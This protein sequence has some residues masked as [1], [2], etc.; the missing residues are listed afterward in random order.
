M[1][2]PRGKRFL[3]AFEAPGYQWLWLFSLFSAMAFTVEFLSYGWAVLQ[4]TN[5]AIWIGLA[6]GVR[7]A[8]QALFSVLG[9]PIVDSVDRRR[10]LLAGQIAAA[11]SALTLALLLLGHTARLWHILCY[12]MLVGLVT[13]VTKPSVSGL[14]YDVVGPRRLLNASAF[15]FM[16]ASLIRIV[17]AVAGGF[18]I[19]RL[20]VGK[21]FLLV[22]SAYCGG[23]GALF[24]L[25]RPAAGVKSTEPFVRAVTTGFGYVLRVHQIRTLVLLSLVVEAFGFGYQAMMPVM[26]RDVLQVGGIGLGYLT[27]MVRRWAT[28]SNAVGGVR[29][30][31][32]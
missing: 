10:L 1:V 2:R 17:G 32:A 26:A 7:G 14:L 30:G 3:L 23:L 19:D 31:S 15:Q 21:N 18:I 16:A 4:L 6:A 12:L 8:S 25:R 24:M 27:A 20:G 29:W 22:F 9:G 5:S 13:A 28:D 11:I